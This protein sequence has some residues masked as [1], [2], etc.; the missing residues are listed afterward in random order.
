MTPF[1]GNELCAGGLSNVRTS[2]AIVQALEL[3]TN[4][5]E[6]T[7]AKSLRCQSRVQSLHVAMLQTCRRQRGYCPKGLNRNLGR[8]L[9][10][11]WHGFCSKTLEPGHRPMPWTWHWPQCW[12]MLVS[13]Y[14]LMD[15]M[16]ALRRCFIRLHPV[17]PWQVRSLSCTGSI[18]NWTG[19]NPSWS[20][21]LHI[22]QQ[23][24]HQ[25]TFFGCQNATSDIDQS[26]SA[27]HVLPEGAGCHGPSQHA[28]SGKQHSSTYF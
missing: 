12:S 21:P 13:V 4:A 28:S 11:F 16:D 27:V 10:S 20:G 17:S 24:P 23:R 15:L 1:V 7:C 22:W 3:Q 26:S 6:P 14:T 5:A 2:F 9:E 25:T 8:N 18:W 19:S